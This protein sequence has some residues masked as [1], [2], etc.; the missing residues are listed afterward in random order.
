[1]NYVR[2]YFIFVALLR[3]SAPRSNRT[4]VAAQPLPL[5]TESS[6]FEQVTEPRS[7]TRG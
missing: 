5:M 7:I 1:M 6:N 4:V 2:Q 3:A